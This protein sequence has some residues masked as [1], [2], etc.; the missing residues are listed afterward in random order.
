MPDKIDAGQKEKGAKENKCQQRSPEE[1]TNYSGRVKIYSRYYFFFIFG[2]LISLI[3]GSGEF[4]LIS[5]SLTIRYIFCSDRVASKHAQYF[6]FA[7]IN[8]PQRNSHSLLTKYWLVVLLFWREIS[9]HE[10]V[11][12]SIL[13]LI[14]KKIL[15]FH[16]RMNIYK[17]R[18]LTLKRTNFKL[19]LFSVEHV[20]R[21]HKKIQKIHFTV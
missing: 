2:S 15:A 16:I 10:A 21:I 11:L 18:S 4:N 14:V 6:L 13:S 7:M 5:R 12:Y 8:H 17:T 3:W 20:A 1:K 19:I 9:P